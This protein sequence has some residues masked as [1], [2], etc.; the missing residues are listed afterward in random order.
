MQYDEKKSSEPE[1]KGDQSA[2]L[3]APRGFFTGARYLW[4]GYRFIREHRALWPWLILPWLMSIAVF[5]CGVALTWIYKD[6]VMALIATKP[7]EMGWAFLWHVVYAL[8][9]TIMLALTY[10]SFVV[11]N[12]I[13]SGFFYDLLSEH[14]ESIE[15]GPEDQRAFFSRC[16]ST[17]AAFDGP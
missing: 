6:D 11:A 4:R 12:A 7:E 2:S 1:G 16:P 9:V 14:C 8:L 13:L 10:L 15:E 5:I 17:R 3:K